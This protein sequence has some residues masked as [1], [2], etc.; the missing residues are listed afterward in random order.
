MKIKGVSPIRAA[1]SLSA[2]CLTACTPQKERNI[3][4]KQVSPPAASRQAQ[5]ARGEQL[6]KQYC[7]ACHPDGGNVSDP[8]RNLRRSTLQANRITKPED[9]VGIMRKPISRMIRF[10][11]AT[12]SNEDARAIAEYVL[13]SF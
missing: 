5:L 4:K 11:A 6:F 3:P 1:V 13:E 12:L 9:I 8:A 10:D 2:I 7:A